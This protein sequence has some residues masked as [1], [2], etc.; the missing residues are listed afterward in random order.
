MRHPLLAGL[1]TA[2]LLG[3]CQT[4]PRSPV[5]DQTTRVVVANPRALPPAP[6]VATRP[7]PPV[8]EPPEED[9]V[10]EV[11][12]FASLRG[13]SA[14]DAAPALLAFRLSCTAWTD[15]EDAAA[16]APNL[17]QYGI[18][19]D[20]REPC[21]AAGEATDAKAFF[22]TH[23][24]PVA[25][26]TP[27]AG[28][29]LLTGYYEPEIAVRRVPSR[30]F[31]EPVLARPDDPAV[32]ALP[33]AEQGPRSSRVIA[34]GRPIDVFFMQVQGSG[35][36]RFADGL[37]LRAAF[38]GHNSLP[39]TSIGRVL[40]ERGEM[41]LSAASKGA[42]ERW[43]RSNGPEA[44]RELM[45]SNA[46]YVFFE[47]QAVPSSGSTGPQGAMRVPLTD[48]GSIALDPRYHP[49]GTVALLETTLPRAK[50][51]FRGVPATLLVVGQDTGGAIR[52]PLRGDLFFGSGEAAGE[53]AGVMKHP[54][55]WTLL[56]PK[57][58]AERYRKSA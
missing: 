20:W 34:Y 44:T 37:T 23:F 11:S 7:P 36:I 52:G 53:L 56:L 46:R 40:V 9:V 31:S 19:A 26:S 5:V 43:M 58:L 33:R 2:C 41:E 15:A 3:A 16:L 48:M 25:L 13:W 22:E 10:E 35:R 28:E 17:P 18:F 12:R 27:E 55:R 30:E 32:Q 54:V 6:P 8:M 47:E 38:A 57:R 29:G 14:T 39:Y 50:G 1:A 45:N 24:T 51:D 42:I 49:Y 21:A 4:P